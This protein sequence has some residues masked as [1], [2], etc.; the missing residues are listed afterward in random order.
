VKPQTFRRN[1]DGT[2]AVEFAITAPVFFMVLF[3][4]IEC[5]R[6]M[7]TQLGLQHAVEM[8]ARCASIN[9]TLCSTSNDIKVFAVQQTYG[10]APP[11]STFTTSTPGNGCGNQV[12]ASYTYQYVSTYFG[13]PSVTLNAQSCFPN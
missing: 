12:N 8:A 13:T 9:K 3:G 10:V 7:W 1:I 5:G 2:T 11:V 6:L 4:I